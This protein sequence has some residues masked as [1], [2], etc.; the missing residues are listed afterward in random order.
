MRVRLSASAAMSP[1]TLALVAMA[2][3]AGV[4]AAS[5]VT[6]VDNAYT[7]LVVGVDDRVDVLQCQDMVRNTKVGTAPQ[8]A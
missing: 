7:G 4:T 1:A 5:R 3:A 6:L 8:T 2:L